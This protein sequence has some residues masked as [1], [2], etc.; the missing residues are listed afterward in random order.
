MRQR[1]SENSSPSKELAIPP[2]PR[3]HPARRAEYELDDTDQRDNLQPDI[4][5]LHVLCR[6]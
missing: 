3:L 6:T 2:R 5:L 1:C 4:K